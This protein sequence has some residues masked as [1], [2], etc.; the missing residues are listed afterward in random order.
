MVS[1]QQQQQKVLYSFCSAAKCLDGWAPHGRLV[2]DS[3]G[4]VY[5]T[6]FGG[7][8]NCQGIGEGG[9]GTAFELSPSGDGTW[10]ETVLYSFGANSTDGAYP[11]A[12]LIF[13]GNGNLYGTTQNGGTYGLGTVF[14][15]R[16]PSDRESSWAE[17][18]LWSFGAKGDGGYPFS[19]LI[20]D[21]PGNLYGTASE[22]GAYGAGIVFRLLPGSGGQ[23]SE[24]I[25]SSFG[26]TT[27]GGYDPE[28]GVT[29]DSL[30]NLY[31]TTVAGGS[32]G[33]G[34]GVVYRL[35][36]TH[37][38]PWAETVLF[39]FSADTGGNPLSTVSFDAAGNLYGTVSEYGGFNGGVFRLSPHS[40]NREHGVLFGG[41]PG[42]AVPYAGVL[43]GGSS[44]YGTTVLGGTQNQGSVFE[45]RGTTQT[46]LYSFCSLPA[47][48][49]G[50][51]PN[52]AV[53]ARD[54]IL[55]GTALNG[56][57]NGEG[58]VVYQVSRTEAR[59]R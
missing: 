42:A 9:C 7:G 13:D 16:P 23:W 26:P 31:G 47:C 29:L 1:A 28:A 54:G 19:D 8:A 3:N 49:D 25:L 2:F 51:S 21:K 37:Q 43:I 32:N 11:S 15:L 38:L 36:P 30:G 14:Q 22:G 55:Y 34:L 48:A 57:A 5:G 40:R 10:T 59:T 6:T 18:V 50:S 35:S 20:F 44:L 33:L 56:G 53:I 4:N 39:R 52:S 46:V 17:A 58:G 41:A 12:G 24:Q 45:I 27:S